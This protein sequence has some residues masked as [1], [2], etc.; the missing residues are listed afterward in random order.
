MSGAER[1]PTHISMPARGAVTE[2]FHLHYRRLVGV[3]A[4]LVDDRETAEDVVQEAF[5]GFTGAGDDC[6][7]PKPRSPT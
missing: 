6:A 1:M 5:E 7:T 2:L 4:L 3:A